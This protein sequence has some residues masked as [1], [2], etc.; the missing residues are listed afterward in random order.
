MR[1]I[2]VQAFGGPE[3]LTVVELPVPEPGEGEVRVRLDAVG[4]N[5][6]E[7]YQRSGYYPAPLPLVPGSEGGGTV[8]AV[9]PGVAS[10]AVG[11]RVV[12]ADLRGA[13]AEQAIVAAGR[14]VP[15]PDGVGTEVATAAAVQGMTAHYLL[16]DCYPVRRGDAVLVHAAAGGMGLLLTQLATRLGA[17]VI[18]TVS[19]VE[20]EE[21][22]RAAGA[23]EVIRYTETDDLP[24]EVRR[25]T[26]GEGVAAVYDGVGK[27]TFDDSLA[28]L[29]VRGTMVLF[30]ASSGPVAPMDPQRLQF[31][32]SLVLT[33]PTLRHFIAADDELR[34]RAGD[35]FGWIADGLNIRVH[36]RYPLVEAG[37][38]HRD[39]QGRRTTGKV[40]L[41]P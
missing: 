37:R 38:A 14:V 26:G 11:D 27:D 20:K 13:Y 10:V 21:L 3:V 29:R 23:A 36:D 35:L 17:R 16:Y 40:L 6:I 7:T 31:G 34:R 33:R 41:I 39:L 8:S 1:A 5:F 15:I 4:V 28:S 22:A 18:G 2:Q 24:G 9:G 19:T 12:S 25:L 32:G 30:G